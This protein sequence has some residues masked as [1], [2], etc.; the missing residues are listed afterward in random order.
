MVKARPRVSASNTHIFLSG[1]QLPKIDGPAW[2]RLEKIYDK[3]FSDDERLMIQDIL[4]RFAENSWSL[5]DG[6]NR[7][8]AFGRQDKEGYAKQATKLMKFRKSLQRTIAAWNLANEDPTLQRVFDDLDAESRCK[9]PRQPQVIRTMTELQALNV[10]MN[11]NLEKIGLVKIRNRDPFSGFVR[12]LADTLKFMGCEVTN[13]GDADSHGK[14]S[15]FVELIAALSMA[16]HA[17][18]SP[19]PSN[20]KADSNWS[21]WSQKIARALKNKK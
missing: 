19:A 12:E 1:D 14:P 6:K 20:T 15:P 3:P 18:I 16:V 5:K 10:Y 13:R 9:G 4:T 8:K 2:G 7:L 11:L 21:A 17:D